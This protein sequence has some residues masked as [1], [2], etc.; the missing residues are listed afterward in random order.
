M[1]RMSINSGNLVAASLITGRPT[2]C[3]KVRKVLDKL[4]LSESAIAALLANPPGA[5]INMGE[6]TYC[7]GRASFI[8]GLASRRGEELDQSMLDR[9]N[10]HT[11]A[12]V[13]VLVRAGRAG[14]LPVHSITQL[15]VSANECE[16]S[17]FTKLEVLELL[18][19]ELA[20]EEVEPL[21]TKWARSL[22]PHTELARSMAAR[23]VFRTLNQFLTSPERNTRRQ[24][25]TWAQHLGAVALELSIP[26]DERLR[27]DA[28]R[29]PNH[30]P[31]D[32]LV[33]LSVKE[34]VD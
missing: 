20:A 33:T 32:V 27:E 8:L 13:K 3:W 31:D 2:G 19:V 18:S 16:L 14:I 10:T 22:G 11:P 15:C 25:E 30:S 24:E 26:L 7:L 6:I 1:L 17:G 29:K 12:A 9:L 23:A 28:E 5:F 21:A 4:A 34:P